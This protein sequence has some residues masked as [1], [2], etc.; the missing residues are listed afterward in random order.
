MPV[1]DKKYVNFKIKEFNSAVN[2]N[3]SG[4]KIPKEGVHHTCIA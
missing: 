1:Y 3:F 4:N 2:T